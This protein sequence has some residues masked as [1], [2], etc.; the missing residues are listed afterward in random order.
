M[1]SSAILKVLAHRYPFLLV[2]RIDVIEP[3]K[4]VEGLK[5]V[6]GAEWFGPAWEAGQAAMPNMLVVEALAQT[7]AAL[8]LGLVDAG[9]AVVGYFAAIERVRLRAPAVAGDTLLLSV[10]LVTFRRGVAHLNGRATV[11]GRRVV[12]ASFT[13][14]VRPGS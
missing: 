1:D 13:T 11:E 8:L 3:G 2:D 9:R 10:E 12:S 6:T 5:R 14:I 4:R 7:S